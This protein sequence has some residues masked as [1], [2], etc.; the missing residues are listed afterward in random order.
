M[1]YP[2][3]SRA[4]PP[5]QQGLVPLDQPLYGATIGQAFVRFWKKYV[6]FSGRASR[7]EFWWAVLITTI[8]GVVIEVIGIAAGGDLLAANSSPTGPDDIAPTI[9]GLATLLPSLALTVRRLHD[10]NRS[11]WWVLIGLIPVVGWIILIVFNATA[12]DPAGARYDQP[13]AV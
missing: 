10:I 7:S 8:I 13:H 9:W 1:S 6:V 11:G 5:G 4:A 3:V 12:A 2:A